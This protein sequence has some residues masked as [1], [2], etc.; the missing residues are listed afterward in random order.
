MA[1]GAGKF[2]A[3][4]R[5]YHDSN[6]NAGSLQDSGC[7]SAQGIESVKR[8]ARSGPQGLMRPKF[9]TRRCFIAVRIYFVDMEKFQDYHTSIV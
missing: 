9:K 4:R 8:I 2:I 1:L 3:G 5:Y 7:L 6:K